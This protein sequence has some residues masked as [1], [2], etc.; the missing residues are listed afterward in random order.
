MFSQVGIPVLRSLSQSSWAG[1]R[2]KPSISRGWKV[3][4]KYPLPCFALGLLWG[5]LLCER[6]W[7]ASYTGTGKR[8]WG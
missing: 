1:Q 4:A 2:L 3:G 7:G 6:G 5:V 8:G